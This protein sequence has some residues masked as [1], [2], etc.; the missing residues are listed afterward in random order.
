MWTECY[1]SAVV[2]DKFVFLLTPNV[3]LLF[4]GFSSP[5]QSGA[6]GLL[7]LWQSVSCQELRTASR[8][9]DWR[10]P[11]HP[12]TFPL[13]APHSSTQQTLT[14][15][16]CGAVSRENT[17]WIILEVFGVSAECVLCPRISYFWAF[18]V[19]PQEAT[20]IF[21]LK[22]GADLLLRKSWRK[23]VWQEAMTPFLTHTHAHTRCVCWCEKGLSGDVMIWNRLIRSSSGWKCVTV[24][25]G[26]PGVAAS[27]S[28]TSSLDLRFCSV[29]R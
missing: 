29:R 21:H 15:P 1:V 19:R 4:L 3:E 25:V 11:D 16:G 14:M 23:L 22:R 13:Y 26:T 9:A 12:G 28:F 18:S 17:A 27:L 8:R 10:L 24:S 5:V 7:E 6:V 20:V 2:D